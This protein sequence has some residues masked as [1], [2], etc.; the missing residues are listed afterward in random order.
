MLHDKGLEPGDDG[1]ADTCFR[2]SGKA[3]PMAEIDPGTRF[4]SF[5]PP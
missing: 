5:S 3:F 1:A 2:M 4:A